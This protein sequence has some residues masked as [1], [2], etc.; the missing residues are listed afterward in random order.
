MLDLGAALQPSLSQ[1]HRY[2]VEINNHELCDPGNGNPNLAF[3]CKRTKK[4][5]DDAMFIVEPGPRAQ[6]FSL[7]LG[8]I[9]S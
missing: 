4:I 3:M 6:V 8:T 2:S 1:V 5:G 7:W 9:K